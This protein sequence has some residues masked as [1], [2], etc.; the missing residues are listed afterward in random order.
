MENEYLRLRPDVHGTDGFFVAVLERRKKEEM[1]VKKEAAEITP[2]AQAPDSAVQEAAEADS[3]VV[4]NEE[5]PEK[6]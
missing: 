6:A 2:D 5:S 4:V 3:S 1:A